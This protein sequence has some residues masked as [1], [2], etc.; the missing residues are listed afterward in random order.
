MWFKNLLVYRFTKPFTF[1]AEEVEQKLAEHAFTPCNSQ[2]ASS[3]GWTTPLGSQGS[4][5]IHRHNDFMMIC[6]KKQDKILPAAVVNEF[7]ADKI[8]EIKLQ[9]DRTPSRKERSDLKD[10]IIFSLTPR[11]F[12]KSN[13]IFAYIAP[14][15]GL[16]VINAGSHNKAEELLNYLRETLGSLPVIPLKAKNMAQHV[17]TEWLSNGSAPAGFE[18][19]GE[20]ELRDKADDSAVIRCKNQNLCSSEIKNHIDSGMFVTKL[21]L[22]WLGDIEFIVD[23]QLTIKRLAFGDLIQDKLGEVDADSAA[24]QFDVDFSIMTGEFAKFIPALLEAFGGEELSEQDP[25]ISSAA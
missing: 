4:E 20:C 2:D 8:E 17:M 7:L 6:A 25:I 10:E 14:E 15:Q 9:E 11:A 23:D 16:L 12:T 21:A 3:Y 22:R 5:Y 24:E 13:Q 19:G 1:T 18:L